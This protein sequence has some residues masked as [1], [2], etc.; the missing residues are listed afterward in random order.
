MKINRQ[1]NSKKKLWIVAGI[2]ALLV[3][4]A[5]G[6]YVFAGR[7]TSEGADKTESVLTSEEEKKAGDQAKTST[8][9]SDTS[10]DTSSNSSKNS[11]S[12]SPS[13]S[14]TVSM[15]IT[16]NS[17]NGT[18]YQVRTLI[19]AIINSGICT[20][21]LT[22]GEATLT[23]TASVQA[24][25]QSSTCQGFDVPTSK[26][27]AGTWQVAISFT[28]AGRTGSANGIVEIR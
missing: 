13:V 1:D 12:V 7:S 17:Q 4:V 2:V 15:Q 5:A 26:L 18:M 10:E 19:N 23:N 20:L 6:W 11:P 8:V 27:S 16:A 3:A 22:K 14:P 21:T 24:S 9:E 28:G 25:A